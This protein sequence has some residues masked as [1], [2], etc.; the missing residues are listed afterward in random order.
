MASLRRL[1]SAASGLAP[2]ARLHAGPPTGPGPM[3]SLR[4]LR[5]AASGLA[6]AARLH[7]GPRVEVGP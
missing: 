4:R 1:R 6:P 7:A 5:S 2:A 3:A